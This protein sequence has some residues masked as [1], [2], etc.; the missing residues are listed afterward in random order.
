MYKNLRGQK[1]NANEIR[2]VTEG[3]TV[4]LEPIQGTGLSITPKPPNIEEIVQRIDGYSK[5]DEDLQV[6]FWPDSFAEFQVLRDA[7]VAEGFHYRPRP[8]PETVRI[9]VSAKSPTSDFAQ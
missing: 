8:V 9:F 7:M 2:E 5:T 3:K 1:S 6:F 4:Y